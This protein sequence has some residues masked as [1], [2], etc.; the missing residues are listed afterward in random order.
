MP[1]RRL[2]CWKARYIRGGE[3]GT[4]DD[5]LADRN[6][7]PDHPAGLAARGVP[8]TLSQTVPGRGVKAPIQTCWEATYRDGQKARFSVNA[9]VAQ[10][11]NEA[12]RR[13]AQKAQRRAKMPN[14]DI[15]DVMLVE[16]R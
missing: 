15:I 9:K 12:V 5:T 11:G 8:L 6:T 14:G 13:W 4:R 3:H 2:V 10:L 7:N 1:V 16:V